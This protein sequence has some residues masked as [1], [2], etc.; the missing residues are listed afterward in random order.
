M[1]AVIF[2]LD[3]VIVHTDKLNYQ[4]WKDLAD[5]L[6]IYFDEKINDRMR[7]VSREGS[8]E[9][10]LERGAR[11]YTA[12]EK[13]AMVARKNAEYK[14]LI[15]TLGEK[16]LSSEV[17]GTLEE[18]RAR[19]LMLALGSSSKNA[20]FI[21]ERIGLGDFFDAIADGTCIK[22]SKPDPE[23]FLTAAEL[24]GVEPSAALVVEDAD[25]GIRAAHTGGF[26]SAAVGPARECPLADY[27]LER[28]S[29]L[30]DIV[31]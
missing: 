28:F 24:L 31:G 8:L 6:G 7:G 19:G 11:T 1:K 29:E 20:R 21:L 25:A 14:E 12:E 13:A 18:L 16:D 26:L 17:K 10:V 2:D 27:R 23:V 4:I 5:E 3:G 30:L 9:I 22:R 15:K